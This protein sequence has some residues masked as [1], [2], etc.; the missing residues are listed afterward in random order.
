MKI[1]SLI[2]D[3]EQLARTRLH[4]MLALEPDIVIAGE[5]SNGA[6]AI[7]FIQSQRPN[8]IFLDVQMPEISGFDVLRALPAASLPAVIFVTAHDQHA[9]EAF[10]VQALDYLLKPFT[11]A[12]LK[13][14]VDRVRRHLQARDISSINQRLSEWLHKLPSAMPVYLN[15]FAIK[16]GSQTTFLKVEDVDYIESASNYAVLHTPNGNHVLRE[17]LVNLESKLSPKKFRRISR[18]VMANLERI[19]EIHADARGDHAVVLQSGKQLDL[20][21][22]VQEILSWMQFP[23]APTQ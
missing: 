18:S 17:T 3:D 5:C 16:N 7:D 14:S 15:R 20:T 10:E 11:Q 4:K 8:L 23:E 19:K 12:R 22:N 9:V 21:R 1:Q 13:E 6:A 2:V